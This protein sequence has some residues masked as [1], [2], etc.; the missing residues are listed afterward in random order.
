MTKECKH[1]E[2]WD[3]QGI[4]EIY[5]CEKCGKVTFKRI[6]TYDFYIGHENAKQEKGLESEDKT[7]KRND[8]GQY[9]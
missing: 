4:C 3:T 2:K 8:G 5:I 7:N 9:Y 6:N 1:E